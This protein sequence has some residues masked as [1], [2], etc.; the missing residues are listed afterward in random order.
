MQITKKPSKLICPVYKINLLYLVKYNVE[1][2]FKNKLSFIITDLFYEQTR[3]DRLIHIWN[4]IINS[5]NTSAMILISLPT[6][7][8]VHNILSSDIEIQF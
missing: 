6:L 3:I 5:I 1:T 4:E 8:Y 7:K 2:I